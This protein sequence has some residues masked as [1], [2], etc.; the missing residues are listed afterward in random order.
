MCFHQ[1]QWL[2]HTAAV[3]HFALLPV[4]L[5]PVYHAVIC[6]GKARW[7]EIN[8]RVSSPLCRHCSTEAVLSASVSEFPPCCHENNMGITEYTVQTGLIGCFK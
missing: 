3:P 1:A 7:R 5:F 4:S 6:R 2:R 8:M